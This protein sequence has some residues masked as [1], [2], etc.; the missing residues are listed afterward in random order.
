MKALQTDLLL[1]WDL[2]R[3]RLLGARGTCGAREPVGAGAVEEVPALW[4]FSVERV[5]RQLDETLD[6]TELLRVTVS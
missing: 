6:K 1:R 5:E 2:S 3:S 4:R